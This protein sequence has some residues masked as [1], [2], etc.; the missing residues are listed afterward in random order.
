M[1]AL[2]T[3]YSL[4]EIAIDV[5]CNP[6]GNT[7]FVLIAKALSGM[8]KI[9]KLWLSVYDIG[10]NDDSFQKFLIEFQKMDPLLVLRLDFKLYS[11]L[12]I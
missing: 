4:R 7:G 10:I 5:S 9:N 1:H 11:E 3:I 12:Y 6:L 2:K 8:R